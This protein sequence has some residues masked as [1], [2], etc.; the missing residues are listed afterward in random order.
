MTSDHNDRQKGCHD[1]YQE[2]KGS[3]QNILGCRFSGTVTD[4]EF[5]AFVSRAEQSITEYGKIRLLIVMDYPQDF[6]L[7]AAWDDVVFWIRHIREIERLAIVGQSAWQKR[8]ESIEQFL[9]HVQIEYY[10]TSDLAEA[11]AWLKEDSTIEQ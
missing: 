3:E 6:D 4:A 7:R 5:K 2:L 10:D 1:V 8:I 9:L 11:W